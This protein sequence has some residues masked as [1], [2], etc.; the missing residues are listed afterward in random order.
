MSLAAR[1]LPAG[2]SALSVEFGAT[3]DPVSEARVLALDTALAARPIPGVLETVPTYRAL[4]VH[5]DPRIWSVAAL[6]QEIDKVDVNYLQAAT[7]IT[8]HIPAC[9]DPPY[10]ED[11][12]EAAG[13]LGLAPEKV[14]ELHAGAEYR[15]VMYG[16]APGFVFLSGLPLALTLSRRQTPRAPAPPG[17]LT[18]AG[19][20][21][22]IASVAMPTGWYM[23]GRTPART[24]DL[25]R[26]PVFPL[27][28]G[29]IV[30]FE[31]IDPARF[32]TL[33]AEAQAGRPVMRETP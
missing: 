1:F 3:I 33:E 6:A 25:A 5:F 4:M 23:L 18:I 29:D 27:G 9:Y 7:S 14:A 13:I 11:L 2:E 19:G 22:L 28:V 21:A 30:R 16:F 26:D 8:W 12:A 10:S 31:R 17:A 24:F 15:V 20:Q 32:A